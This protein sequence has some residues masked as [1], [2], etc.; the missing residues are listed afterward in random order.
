MWR[1]MGPSR[2]QSG[3]ISNARAPLRCWTASG[4]LDAILTANT[5]PKNATSGS[6]VNDEI[7]NLWND[8]HYED[9]QEMMLQILVS[10]MIDATD[11]LPM[12]LLTGN[13]H[14]FR[15]ISIHQQ[16]FRLCPN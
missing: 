8:P 4:G 15:R 1:A 11:P 14:S 5:V 9:T 3:G 12:R 16:R 13:R 2:N 10:G 7:N 6:G